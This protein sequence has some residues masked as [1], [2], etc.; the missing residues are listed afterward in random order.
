MIKYWG[1]LS[2]IVTATAIGALVIFLAVNAISGVSF[3]LFFGDSKPL[4][5]I[6]GK[7]TVWNGLWSPLLGTLRLLSL[8][9]LFV[10]PMGLAVGMYASEYASGK[11]ERLVTAILESLAGIP[12]IIMGLF[13][14]TLILILRRYIFSANTCM[15][16]AAF[17]LAL[18]ALPVLSLNT[19]AALKGVPSNVRLTAA[20]LGMSKETAIV[21]IF[22]PVAGEGIFSGLLLSAARCAE[23]AA[24]ILLTGAVAGA[25][26]ITGIF[27]KF[28]AL[29]FFIYYVSANYQNEVQLAQ[30]FAAA[31]LLLAITT[32]LF[33]FGTVL[34]NKSR[35]WM[36]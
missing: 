26:N 30:V 12:S 20:S 16:L 8:T 5:A 15:L 11:R 35:L 25:G 2:S 28:E 24:V 3:T 6:L 17:C 14:F 10:I 22:V 29:P 32:A 33:T 9:G 19:Y 7:V 27:D 21:R 1:Y 23:D 34:K 13:G 31:I 36:R 18:L 4:D